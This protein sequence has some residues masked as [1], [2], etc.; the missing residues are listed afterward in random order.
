MLTSGCSLTANVAGT[1]DALIRH[2]GFDPAALGGAGVVSFWRPVCIR[3]RAEPQPPVAR[4]RTVCDSS[5]GQRNGF[6]ACTR[7]TFAASR[8]AARNGLVRR[9][10]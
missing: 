10:E 8:R 4:V 7:I 5:S 9:H 3:S 1:R 2:G 6:Q